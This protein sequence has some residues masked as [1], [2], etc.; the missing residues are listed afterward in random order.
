MGNKP[1]KRIAIV[2]AGKRPEI[3]EAILPFIDQHYDLELTNDR[4]ADYVFHSCLGNKVC[5]TPESASSLPVN[6]SS[7]TS[8]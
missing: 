1:R 7:P 4:D 3:V 8:M 6:T 2:D 5:A